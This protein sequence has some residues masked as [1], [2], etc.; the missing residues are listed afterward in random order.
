MNFKRRRRKSWVGCCS[1]CMMQHRS[2]LHHR[3]LTKQERAAKCSEREQLK[4]VT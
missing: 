1:L 3:H 2:D 4:E